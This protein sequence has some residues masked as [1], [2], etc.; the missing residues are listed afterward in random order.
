[1]SG[2][3]LSPL[4]ESLPCSPPAHNC[5]SDML[6]PAVLNLEEHLVAAT[7]G[8]FSFSFTG[9]ELAYSVRPHPATTKRSPTLEESLVLGRHMG[10]MKSGNLILVL[11]E[12]YSFLGLSKILEI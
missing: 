4:Q 5:V 10:L 11:V 2:P 1:M 6:T 3:P 8:T 9:L 7:T 12:H